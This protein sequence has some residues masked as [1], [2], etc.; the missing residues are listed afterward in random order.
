[1]CGPFKAP[2]KFYIIYV[3]EHINFP[4]HYFGKKIWDGNHVDEW[5]RE[6]G[7]CPTNVSEVNL[8]IH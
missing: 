4:F 7:K 8:A 5:K 6:Q 1:M 2:C 3:S